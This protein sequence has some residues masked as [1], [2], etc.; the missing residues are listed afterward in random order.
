MEIYY[1]Q[2]IDKVSDHLISA[3]L[4]LEKIIL[5]LSCDLDGEGDIEVRSRIKMQRMILRNV[6]DS[7][8]NNLH[9]LDTEQ[10]KKQLNE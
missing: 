6:Y 2:E 8:V 5:S 4:D 1:E 10:M 3:K 9:I 7:L